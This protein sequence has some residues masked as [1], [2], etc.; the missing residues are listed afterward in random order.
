MNLLEG[1]NVFKD[2]DGNPITGRINQTDIKPTVAWLE[3]LTGLPLLDNMLGSTGLK[4]SSGDLDLAVDATQVTKDQLIARL[5][6]WAKSHGFDPAHWIKKSGISVHFLTPIDGRQSRGYVQTDFMFLN[7]VP[8]SKFILRGD[9]NSQFKGAARNVL[10]NSMA[11]SMG[12][13]LNQTAG[14]ADRATNQVITDDPDKIAKLLLNKNATRN[15]LA[16]VESILL[17]LKNDPKKEAK[18]ADFRAHVEREG[19]PLPA[20]LEENESHFLARLRDRIVNQ[21]MQPL[22]ENESSIRPITEAKEDVRI[23]HIEDL[24]F[25]K[26]AAGVDQALNI[27]ADSAKNTA[28][29]VTIKW[30]G[31]PAIFFG[32]K[33]T[34]EFV[35]TDKS[36]LMAVG[37]DGLATSPKMIGDIMR[38]RD[39]AAVAK[40][41]AATR[42]AELIPMY[43]SIWPYFEAATPKDFRGYVKGDLLYYPQKPYVEEAGNFVFRPN[44]TL[45]RIPV[46]SELGQRIAGTEVGIAIHTQLDDEGSRERPI[47]PALEL[48]PVQGLLASRPNV[49]TLQAIDPNSKLIKQIK[50][51]LNKNGAAITQLLNPNELRAMKITDLPALMESFINSL[52]GTD[53]SQATPS[54]FGEWLK[55]KVT[56]NKF[57]NI[58][59]YLN[60]PKSNVSGMAAAFTLWNLLHTLKMDILRQLDLQ[61][62]GQEG[63]VLATPAGRAKAVSRVAG[64][65]TAANRAR[66]NPAPNA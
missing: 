3:Q 1:G 18:L 22:I 2:A 51:V 16:S 29:Y 44:E 15:D 34:G 10:L 66:N 36:G 20:N 47:D 37:Y 64:G 57:R 42:G 32:R 48:N 45:Y 6:E 40:G 8:F 9:I 17:A 12:Y 49:S 55:T 5:S 63:W 28:Q 58:V 21:G 59:E 23:P 35:L 61:Q 31:K 13:K 46:A 43:A 60:S 62:P 19:S 39:A 11:K 33:P 4:P 41:K 65:F 53:F 30:D 38:R 14:I 26:G 52:V 25:Q 24:V 54:Q 56:P 7:N 27:I 50:Q